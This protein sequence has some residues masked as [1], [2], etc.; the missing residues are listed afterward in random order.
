M[1]HVDITK[2]LEEL[3]GRS[4]DQ[5]EFNSQLVVRTHELRKKPLNE[6]SYEDL[7]LLILQQISLDVLLPLAL[8]R[9]LQNP[10]G[11]GD[12][13]VGD[14]FCSVLKVNKEYWASNNELK[15]ELDEV[16]IRYEDAR[17][18]VDNDISKYRSECK[19]Y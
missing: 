18:T 12:L 16:I 9:L 15:T 2:T 14:L 8:E 11:S 19:L 6:F 13:Y 4:W 10:L 5:P 1:N 17:N 3:E 7:R